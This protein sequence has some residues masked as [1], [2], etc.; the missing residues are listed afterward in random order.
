MSNKKII[1]FLYGGFL[2]LS[3]GLGFVYFTLF[4]YQATWQQ[5]LSAA[6]LGIAGSIFIV[7][8]DD[9]EGRGGKSNG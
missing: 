3:S 8:S 1:Y 7:I 2:M 5:W 6:I 9:Y 4:R